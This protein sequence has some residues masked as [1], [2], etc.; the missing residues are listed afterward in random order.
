VS[1]GEGGPM[2]IAPADAAGGIVY[3]TT[4]RSSARKGVKG[5][6]EGVIDA[7]FPDQGQ[8]AAV[9]NAESTGIGGPT[10]TPHGKMVAF[11]AQDPWGNALAS[12]EGNTVGASPPFLGQGAAGTLSEFGDVGI[13]TFSMSHW[14]P[15]DR[16]MVSQIGA[17]AESMLT[18]FDLESTGFG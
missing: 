11:T 16:V 7:V 17:Y 8:K 2:T 18:W 3:W 13:S 12:I 1:V 14:K 15:G 4:S 6:G 9:E 5:G 10:S